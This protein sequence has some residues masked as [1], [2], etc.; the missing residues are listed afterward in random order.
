MHFFGESKP[1][2]YKQVAGGTVGR[3]VTPAVCFQS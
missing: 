3:G 1:S 2:P